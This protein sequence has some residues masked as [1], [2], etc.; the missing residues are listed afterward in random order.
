MK[1]FLEEL[2]ITLPGYENDDLTYVIDIP[3][4]DEYARVFSRLD[5]NSS[6][7]EL[8][9]EEDDMNFDVIKYESEFYYIDLISDYDND[10]YRLEC[11]QK[12]TNV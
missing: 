8:P 9:N 1:D 3:S 4:S 11:Y 7:H 2:G 6:L 5:N 12:E 10:E